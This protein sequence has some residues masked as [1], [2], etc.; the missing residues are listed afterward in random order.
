MPYPQRW[1]V[2]EICREIFLMDQNCGELHLYNTFFLHFRS[3]SN[4][5]FSD[6]NTRVYDDNINY[7]VGLFT[8][9]I[10][11]EFSSKQKEDKEAQNEK[12]YEAKGVF[13]QTPKPDHKLDKHPT[14]YKPGGDVPDICKCLLESQSQTDNRSI[15]RSINSGKTQ[16][17]KTHGQV[18]AEYR[19][20]QFPFTYP[21]TKSGSGSD[22]KA[23]ALGPCQLFRNERMDSL[24]SSKAQ[25]SNSDSHNRRSRWNGEV[26]LPKLQ[27]VPCHLLDQLKDELH[28]FTERKNQRFLNASFRERLAKT[29]GIAEIF[30]L[31]LDRSEYVMWF[32]NEDK[33]LHM[34]N[35]MENS[36]IYMG[37]DLE[38]GVK[39]YLIHPDKLCY[40][41]EDTHE[42]V[43]VNEEERRLDEEFKNHMEEIGFEKML[44]EA[45]ANIMASKEEKAR[46]KL[47]KKLKVRQIV[48]ES[49]GAVEVLSGW[50]VQNIAKFGKNLTSSEI[51][52]Y[53][54]FQ[55]Y[56]NTSETGFANIYNVSGW[57][58]DEA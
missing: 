26:S 50:P 13:T 43:P 40:V 37:S 51:R 4:P 10:Y 44:L 3:Q 57:N 39:N 2:N 42:R 29:F 33:C 24:E 32:L 28:A 52:Y 27:D 21:S 7:G 17:Q 56:P 23:R 45:K 38:E 49:G 9:S 22:G 35:D 54:E 20:G 12:V 47:N 36:L 25:H 53:L 48:V 11:E 58:E 19:S 34:W 8:L 1:T 14:T 16:S 31:Y 18:S 15:I 55:E 41:I 6:K 5:D 46:K 30:P